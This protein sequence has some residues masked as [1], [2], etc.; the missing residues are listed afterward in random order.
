MKLEK[1]IRVKNKMG[2]HTRPATTIVRMLQ[3]S[4]T[5]VH[6][7]CREN[8]INAKSIL[9]IL[10]LAATKN[11]QITINCE[12]EEA[13]KTMKQLVDGFENCFGEV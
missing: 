10:M 6:F 11:T 9:G 4:K 8:T 5:V 2:L 12:G 13:E 3:H 7:T 1:K